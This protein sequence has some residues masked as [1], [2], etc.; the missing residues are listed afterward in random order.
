[1]QYNATLR[2]S[3]PVPGSGDTIPAANRVPDSLKYFRERIAGTTPAGYA[4]TRPLWGVGSPP[5]PDNTP[6]YRA[7]TAGPRIPGAGRSEL[8]HVAGVPGISAE[9]IRA[10]NRPA[11][12]R[13]ALDVD[14]LAPAVRGRMLRRY[15]AR[16]DLEDAR[17]AVQMAALAMLE[18]S[19]VLHPGRV[20]VWACNIGRHTI[21]EEQFRSKIMRD[22][23]TRKEGQKRV[24]R[25]AAALLGRPPATLP[26]AHLGENDRALW[27]DLA[28]GHTIR[29]AAAARGVST[30]AILTRRAAIGAAIR[31]KMR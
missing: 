10:N 27:H 7:R 24:D 1:M 20:V 6:P 14:R 15:G 31:R 23:A 18:R 5:E 11:D 4:E 17:D 19:I 28:A 25:E 9:F 30:R 13:H 3:G 21:R 2:P 12:A 8:Q 16:I 22:F 29:R 26:T